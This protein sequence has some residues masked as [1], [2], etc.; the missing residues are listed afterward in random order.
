MEG[1]ADFW[2]FVGRRFL[3]IGGQQEAITNEGEVMM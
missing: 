1:A 3:R 2:P